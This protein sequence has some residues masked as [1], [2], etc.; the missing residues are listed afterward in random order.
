MQQSPSWEVNRLTASQ[1]TVRI[2]RN[3]KV[4][5]IQVPA[6]CTILNQIYPFHSSPSHFLKIHINIS[7]P[8]TPGSSKKRLCPIILLYFFSHEMRTNFL[9][10]FV[11]VILCAEEYAGKNVPCSTEWMRFCFEIISVEVVQ[12]KRFVQCF[13]F[14][15]LNMTRYSCVQSV[16]TL[17][18]SCRR[19]SLHNVSTRPAIF[20]EL[21]KKVVLEWHY[22]CSH[23]RISYDPKSI[24]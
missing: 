9:V 12:Q 16:E 22:S 20:I 1:E 18:T 8:S 4:P 7:F 19:S 14:V 17:I 21:Q 11:H 6:T 2:L 5:R 13:T 15:F 3:P 24:Q 23:L 10:K